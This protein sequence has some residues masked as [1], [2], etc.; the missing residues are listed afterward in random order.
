MSASLFPTI[1]C[2]SFVAYSGARIV[3][4]TTYV[5]GQPSSPA[6]Q[7]IANAG[8]KSVVCVRKPGEPHT[9]PPYP[10][11]PPFDDGEAAELAKYGVSYQNIPI[12]RD[13]TQAQFDASATEAALAFLRNISRGSAL[14]H[15]STGDRASSVFAVMLILLGQ[16]PD[17]VI[18]YAINS[19]L[20]ANAQIVALVRGYRPAEAAVAEM[21]EA[22][23]ATS[24]RMPS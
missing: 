13:M 4:D 5:T 3:A 14:I 9:P 1:N 10:P 12:T 6:Y 2:L 11:P 18:E 23:A 24:F 20:L 15:C 8:I 21:R 22:A 17:A 16:R 7:A 19:L